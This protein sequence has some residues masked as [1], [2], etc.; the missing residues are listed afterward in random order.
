MEAN[1]PPGPATGYLTQ[2]PGSYI[3]SKYS[4]NNERGVLTEYSLRMFHARTLFIH[5]TK[6][7]LAIYRVYL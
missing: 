6:L 5:I 4:H 2:C 1:K 3:K 7:P